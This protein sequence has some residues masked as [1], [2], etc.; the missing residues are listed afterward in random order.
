M[1]RALAVS[2]CICWLLQSHCQG[3]ANIIIRVLHD[4]TYSNM[5]HNVAADHQNAQKQKK[6]LPRLPSKVATSQPQAI[7]AIDQQSSN[8]AVITQPG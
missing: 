4:Y 6:A 7:A 8:S 3:S 1:P 5:C 2:C